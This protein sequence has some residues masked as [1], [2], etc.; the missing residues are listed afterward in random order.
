MAVLPRERLD[1][2]VIPFI[3]IGI[4]YFAPIKVKL[5]RRNLRRW[6]CLFTC[7]TIRAVHI[8]LAQP[9]ETDSCLAAVSR[10]FTRR[11]YPKTIMSDDERKF[12]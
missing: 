9:L 2:H 3:H 5:L 11:G 7:I 8:K 4:E 12:N 6:H 1:E 10:F